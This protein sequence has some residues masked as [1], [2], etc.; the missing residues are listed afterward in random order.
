M[1]RAMSF[2]GWCICGFLFLAGAG[3]GGVVDET[4]DCG[5]GQATPSGSASGQPSSDGSAPNQGDTATG[6]K[7]AVAGQ[8]DG[9]RWELPCT[10]P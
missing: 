1:N 6:A 7:N 9:L 2:G 3:C 8:L 10:P 5:D 4:T